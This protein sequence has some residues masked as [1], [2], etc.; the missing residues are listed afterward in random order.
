MFFNVNNQMLRRSNI[1]FQLY[2]GISQSQRLRGSDEG[3]ISPSY[4]Y[5][6]KIKKNKK[7][8]E[9][10]IFLLIFASDN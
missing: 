3:I 9:N 10:S 4:K 2:G 5:N 1:S 7:N 8:F 6:R